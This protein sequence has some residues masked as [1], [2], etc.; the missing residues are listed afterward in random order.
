MHFCLA[1]HVLFH[2][3]H[4]SWRFR[5]DSGGGAVS[6]VMSGGPALLLAAIQ[7]G[8]VIDIS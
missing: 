4:M 6:W 2:S 7:C 3:P 8:C 1:L 5:K